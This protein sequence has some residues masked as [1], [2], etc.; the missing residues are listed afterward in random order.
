LI[1]PGRL[2]IGSEKLQSHDTGVGRSKKEG[3]YRKLPSEASK[4]RVVGLLLWLLDVGQHLPS[5]MNYRATTYAPS[6]MLQRRKEEGSLVGEYAMRIKKLTLERGKRHA[7]VQPPTI[8]VEDKG[9]TE[10]ARAIKSKAEG[11]S[12]PKARL[13]SQHLTDRL[14]AERSSPFQGSASD[15][16]IGARVGA[17][18]RGEAW[19]I[20]R[21]RGN[22]LGMTIDL[23]STSLTDEG[24]RATEVKPRG[25]IHR[26]L[27]DHAS[28]LS[29]KA[30]IF[31][32][33]VTQSLGLQP[34][35]E[36]GPPGCKEAMR[37]DAAFHPHQRDLVWRD[38]L[39]ASR[40]ESTRV[41]EVALGA[42]A[43]F[44]GREQSGWKD[45]SMIFLEDEMKILQDIVGESM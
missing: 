8:G 22:E 3:P 21:L 16:K 38:G 29:K 23:Q 36:Q 9:H 14:T 15:P 13:S 43:P 34:N 27:E 33:E 30:P 42:A 20:K 18:H 28:I 4:P 1:V 25:W 19:T 6:P 35:G 17:T 5:P 40:A 37:L 11:L 2:Y 31:M 39:T 26:P 45:I 24:E 41:L 7:I 32:V 12:D 44:K 10:A